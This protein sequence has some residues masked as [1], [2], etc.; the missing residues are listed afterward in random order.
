MAA[1]RGYSAYY[2]QLTQDAS[3]RYEEK[4]SVIGSI[5]PYA[6]DKTDFGDDINKWPRV[7]YMDIV[8]YLVYTTGFITQEEMKAKKSLLA[9]KF[10]T[11]GMVHEVLST[12]IN[13]KAL[14]RGKVRIL[15]VYLRIW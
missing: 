5:D 14:L 13:G 12:T 2:Y 3:E 4:I 7:S 9:Y 1:F 15:L 11:D 10:F 6:L 8:D